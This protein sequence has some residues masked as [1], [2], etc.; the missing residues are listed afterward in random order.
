MFRHEGD[1]ELQDILNVVVLVNGVEE[2][3]HRLQFVVEDTVPFENQ[4]LDV[5]EDEGAK[6]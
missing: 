4:L 6:G 3:E 5:E 2:V 1:E